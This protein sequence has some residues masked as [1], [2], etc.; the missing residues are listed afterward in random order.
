MVLVTSAFILLIEMRQKVPGTWMT[1][2]NLSIL[3]IHRICCKATTSAAPPSLEKGE[4][5]CRF[6]VKPCVGY[7]VG[8]REM[9]LG[10][11][12]DKI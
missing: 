4:G 6:D 5:E 2:E 8:T 7:I 10:E 11:E 3:K 12:N 9:T 1:K